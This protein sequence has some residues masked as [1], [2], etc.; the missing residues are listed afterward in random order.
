ME[1]FLVRVSYHLEGDAAIDDERWYNHDVDK[2]VD[3][4]N[5][6]TADEIIQTR[7]DAG[8]FD[9]SVFMGTTDNGK[10]YELRPHISNRV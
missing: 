7:I 4:I 9:M 2:E 8:D 3:A 1:T 5:Q 10:R 6:A